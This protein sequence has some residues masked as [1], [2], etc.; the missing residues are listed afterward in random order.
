MRGHLSHVK[1]L[2]DYIEQSVKKSRAKATSYS[3]LFCQLKSIIE[4][5][6]HNQL[7]VNSKVNMIIIALPEIVVLISAFDY[8]LN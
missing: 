4:T 2:E 1:N 3:N 8:F 6:N 7:R 5:I